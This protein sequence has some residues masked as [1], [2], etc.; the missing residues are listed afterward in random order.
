[1]EEIINCYFERLQIHN[2]NDLI[3]TNEFQLFNI[4]LKNSLRIENIN[5]NNRGNNNLQV[6]NHINNLYSKVIILMEF[7]YT[8]EA[9]IKAEGNF[10]NKNSKFHVPK[11]IREHEGLK[12]SF[13]K[14]LEKLQNRYDNNINFREG[15]RALINNIN[16]NIEGDS[17]RR[18]CNALLNKLDNPQG[19]NLGRLEIL[20]LI[21]GER[22]MYVH[23]GSTSINGMNYDDREFMLNFYSDY[24]CR[25][26]LV[27]AIYFINIR[28]A[29]INL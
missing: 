22:N 10:T 27:L 1:M 8:Y 6:G 29:Q 16:T 14:G 15:F 18:N 11:D 3:Q 23:N 4:R 7:W 21:Y 9:L 17:I 5:F 25:H 28:L 19:V 2:N 13:D 12:I 26:I 20:A 24:L